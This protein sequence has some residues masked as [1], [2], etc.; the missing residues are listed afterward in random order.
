MH[1]LGDE[2]SSIGLGPRSVGARHRTCGQTN[3]TAGLVTAPHTHFVGP[4]GAMP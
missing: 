2:A 1:R 3:Q 4:F